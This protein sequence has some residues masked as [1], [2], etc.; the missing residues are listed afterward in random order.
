MRNM[1]YI[2]ILY[3]IILYYILYYYVY[4]YFMCGYLMFIYI[5]IYIC[6]YIPLLEVSRTVQFYFNFLR[7]W[8]LSN[9][10]VEFSALL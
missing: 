10:T 3:Y 1:L 5:Y 9:S 8:E 4:M 6:F 2:Y 7:D